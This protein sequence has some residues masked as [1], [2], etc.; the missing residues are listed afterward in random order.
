MEH[1]RTE[2]GD[3]N[4]CV[5]SI[6]AHWRKMYDWA[7]DENVGYRIKCS[8]NEVGPYFD[9]PL[10]GTGHYSPTGEAWDYWKAMEHRPDLLYENILIELRCAEKVGDG[11]RQRR[12]PDQG[13]EE[14]N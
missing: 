4:R 14:R 1:L 5:K 10:K 2:W 3:I 7:S 6:I 11:R 12:R 9:R 8:D 13:A